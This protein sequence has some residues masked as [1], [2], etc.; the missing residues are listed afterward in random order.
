MRETF[1]NTPPST[2]T[3]GGDGDNKLMKDLARRVYD[4]EKCLKNFIHKVDIDYIMQ[5]LHR[6]EKEK[7]N[8]SDFNDLKSLFGN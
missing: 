7:A 1:Y 8:L 2:G 6:L 4:L 3:G 5:E